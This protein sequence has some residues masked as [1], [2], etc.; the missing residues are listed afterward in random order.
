MRGGIRVPDGCEARPGL[1]ALE[2]GGGHCEGPPGARGGGALRLN[3]L[4]IDMFRINLLWRVHRLEAQVEG[5]NGRVWKWSSVVDWLPDWL[6][7]GCHVILP[8]STNYR[9]CELCGNCR[10]FVL[11]FSCVRLR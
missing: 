7:V 4:G 6:E 1:I 8:S 9:P 5:R 2:A 10:W 11:A 3:T